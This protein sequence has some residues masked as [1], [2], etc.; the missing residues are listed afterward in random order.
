MLSANSQRQLQQLSTS[1]RANPTNPQP[2][3]RRAEFWIE[4]MMID[5]ARTDLERSIAIAPTGAAYALLAKI[6][7]TSNAGKTKA[8]EYLQKGRNCS[9]HDMHGLLHVADVY[10]L[11]DKYDAAIECDDAALKLQPN[12]WNITDWRARNMMRAG[13]YKEAIA[14]AT[15]VMEKL[16]PLEKIPAMKGTKMGSMKMTLF[17][18]QT[19][20]RRTRG[21]SFVALHRYSEALP[22]LSL[23]LEL[24]PTDRELL[25]ARAAV[26]QALGK[27]K[28][29]EED[30]RRMNES[31]N[32]LFDNAP[33][34]GP[35]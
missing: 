20:T 30:L 27:P 21:L 31:R 2:Y 23:A 33:F 12:D 14:G 10:S 4:F 35:L 9:A 3:L 26:Y 16:P 6:T 19:D 13:H 8:L 5:R 17:E 1:I 7:A 32:F 24:A 34:A 29:A 22:D 15:Y 11:L 18:L 28:L 25:K